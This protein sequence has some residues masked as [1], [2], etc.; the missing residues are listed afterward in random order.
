MFNTDEEVAGEE[1]L[2]MKLDPALIQTINMFVVDN[3]FVEENETGMV[4]ISC[5]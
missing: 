4:S 1:S 5:H 2:A 3:V